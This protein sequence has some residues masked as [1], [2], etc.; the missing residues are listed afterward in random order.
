LATAGR[1]RL[2]DRA[3]RLAERRRLTFGLPL[4]VLQQLHQPLNLRL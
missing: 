1:L 2:T 4:A 3:F